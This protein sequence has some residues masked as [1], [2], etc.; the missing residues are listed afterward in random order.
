M[1]ITKLFAD[2]FKDTLLSAGFSRKGKLYYRVKGNTVQT[3]LL[4]TYGPFRLLYSVYPYWCHR[5]MSPT[6]NY[7]LESL[8]KT[9]W[10][11]GPIRTEGIWYRSADDD[12]VQKAMQLCL[13]VFI[14]EIFTIFESLTDE[15]SCLAASFEPIAFVSAD[16]P[17]ICYGEE[18][19]ATTRIGSWKNQYLLLWKAYLDGSF[20]EA[21]QMMEKDVR[22]YRE[23]ERESYERNHPAN[24]NHM[25]NI[26]DHVAML[27]ET[28]PE[29]S[30]EEAY[31]E[32][33]Q[34]WGPKNIDIEAYLDERCD[35]FIQAQYSVFLSRMQENDINWIKGF[36][37]EE[38]A[39]MKK[40][41]AD[42]Y[43]LKF[44]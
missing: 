15:A 35:Q 28:C 30:K 36:R 10:A 6:C 34:I 13:Q 22:N 42:V 31:A 41:F 33:H 16:E 26:E 39:I 7:T 8:K 27:A 43:E 40:A 20:S 5:V 37:D 9:W 29:M 3:V 2:T 19:W 11:D 17:V 25:R 4:D 38:S 32:A 24:R 12:D 18:F 21:Y 23:S 14:K 44:D 1:T